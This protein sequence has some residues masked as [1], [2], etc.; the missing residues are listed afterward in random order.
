MKSWRERLTLPA[1][2]ASEAAGSPASAVWTFPL[3]I[4][5]AFVVSWG[6]EAAEFL[7]SQGLA[8]AILALIQTL[9]EFAVEAV[10]AWKAGKDPNMVHL[11]IANFTGSLRL[12]TGLGWP[13]IYA[14]AAFYSRR[15]HGRKLGS[16]D[17]HDDHAVE[18]MGL[19][20]PLAWFIV[21]WAKSS[22]SLV[23]AFV[24]TTTYVVYLV[25]LLKLPPRDETVEED[26]EIPRVSK[27]ALSQTGWKRWAAVLGLL[28]AGGAIIF[29]VAEPFLVSMMALAATMGISQFVFIQWVAP[30][31]SEFPEKT[32]AFAW[33]R[34]VT[35]APVALMNMVSSNINQWGVLSAMLAVIYCLSKGEVTALPFDEFQRLEILLTIVQA[36]LGWI[37]LASMSLSAYEA[38]G[39]FVLWVIQF[40][41]PSLRKEMLWVYGAWIVFELVRIVIGKQKIRAF[42]ALARVWKKRKR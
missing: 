34:R 7:I 2:I 8:L 16:I 39:L 31:L 5:A 23:D 9:P 4:F 30:F 24:L 14:V 33:A 12:L 18:V 13:M 37:F 36:F 29:F 40:V 42:G 22:L 41:R 32:S 38:A 10:I 20:P 17:L 26:E 19:L 3:M 25:V 28:V 21:V 27:W 35:R 11:A 1:A 15:K 6:A